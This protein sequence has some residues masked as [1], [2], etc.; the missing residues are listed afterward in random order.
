MDK[1]GRVFGTVIRVVV[2]IATLVA[3]CMFTLSCM[4]D[5]PYYRYIFGTIR[6]YQLPFILL[7]A[8]A[9]LLVAWFVF[10]GR[11]ALIRFLSL[12]MLL[13]YACTL[14]CISE[15]YLHNKT[16]M[17][18]DEIVMHYGYR[19]EDFVSDND[20][21]MKYADV[22]EISP[23]AFKK[24]ECIE[25]IFLPDNFEF[26]KAVIVKNKP[27]IKDN[28]INEL[29]FEKA[30]AD[31]CHS[32]NTYILLHKKGDPNAVK[33]VKGTFITFK[34]NL[35]NRI[36]ARGDNSHY[37]QD[38]SSMTLFYIVVILIALCWLVSKDSFKEKVSRTLDKIVEI[39]VGDEE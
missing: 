38:F 20:L 12:A 39:I 2:Y 26:G 22:K 16:D 7:L 13:V 27:L 23:K 6:Y 30:R 3:L 4:Y 5:G 32:T 24:I 14:L 19:E 17:T 25:Y 15:I 11:R 33:V 36:F 1:T 28:E 37:F 34:N 8:A 21:K 18:E 10:K 29:A 35:V 9:L 31:S